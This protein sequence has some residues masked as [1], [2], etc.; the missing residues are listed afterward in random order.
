MSD[1]E[2]EQH[3]VP[4]LFEHAKNVYRDMHA[5]AK[6]DEDGLLVYEGHLT[7]LFRKLRLSVPYY[8]S[9]KNQLVAMGCI[10]QTRRGGGNGTSRWV[11]WKEPLL[12]EWK[13]TDAAR[14]RRGNK[15][16]QL[17]Q[18]VKDIADRL[19]QIEARLEKAGL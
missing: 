11:L 12:E 6:P 1:A 14:P 2:L 8:T 10:E 5:E 19:H 13:A 18:R 3:V 9:I 7:V 16:T 17:E 15:T 4:A